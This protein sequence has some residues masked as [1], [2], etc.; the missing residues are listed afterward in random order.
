MPDAPVL[1]DALGATA[2]RP[3]PAA[4]VADLDDS[5]FG[6]YL[7]L[8]RAHW[9]ELARTRQME[10]T[11]ATLDSIRALGD[12]ISLDQ[13]RQ[14]FLPLTELV[15]VHL[16]HFTGLSRHSNWYLGLAEQPTPFVI[17]VAGSVA[18][19]KSTTARLLR[20]L[21]SHAHPARRVD[22]VTT[23]GFL[24]PNA[25][26]ER[27]GL[28]QRKGFPESYDQAALLRFVMDVKSGRPEVAAPVYSHLRYDIVPG[29]R[30]VIRQPDILILEGL[31]VLQPA[32]RRSDGRT[33]LAVSDFF[34][35]TV[36]VDA[37][38]NAVR[39]WFIDR[40]RQL[41]RTAFTDP[42]SYFRRFADVP[43]DEAVAMACQTWDQINGPNLATNIKPTRGRATVVIGKAPDH[44]IEWVRLRR[45]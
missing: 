37:P 5:P 41:W 43:E 24:L 29:Q 9:S 17:A 3:R 40:F 11:E 14:V 26:L 8:R 15:N 39:Q 33:G 18:V 42:D 16:D 30:T 13:V 35:F 1:D 7:C 31:N 34:D 2:A 6:P 38:D 23:D 45:I 21:L 32:R 28:M 27:L 36:Y 25:E 12:P 22:L 20:E 44:T 19:G 4:D 10:L